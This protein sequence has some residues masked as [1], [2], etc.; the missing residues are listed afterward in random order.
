MQYDILGVEGERSV[1]AADWITALGEALE[2]MGLRREVLSQLVIDVGRSGEVDVT[3]PGSGLSFRLAPVEELFG[4]EEWTE[5]V[6]RETL[7]PDS[8]VEGAPKERPPDLAARLAEIARGVVATGDVESASV[9]ALEGLRLLVPAESGA[10]LIFQGQDL[11]FVAAFGPVAAGV[12]GARLATDAGV[13]GFTFQLGLGVVVNRAD[14]DV[15]HDKTIDRRL[16]Y[17]TRSI[18]AAPLM[19][20]NGDVYGVLQLVNAPETFRD[21]HLEAAQGVAG[22]LAA[23]LGGS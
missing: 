6:T 4:G 14:L 22:D 23:H 13:A 19:D 18:V 11:E 17:R 1:Y 16:N 10:V 7:V 3:D 21:W 12:R 20:A 2:T 15:R 5:E 9:A 8:A